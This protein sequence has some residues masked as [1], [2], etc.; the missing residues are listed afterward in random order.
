LEAD[1]VKDIT[2][3]ICIDANGKRFEGP[4]DVPAMPQDYRFVAGQL[5]AVTRVATDHDSAGAIQIAFTAVA[6]I[7]KRLDEAMAHG[8]GFELTQS[9]DSL[10]PGCELELTVRIMKPD[11]A[12]P[13]YPPTGSI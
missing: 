2:D 6:W 4:P 5:S 8:Q 1:P 9:T 12:G 11:P 7:A 13:T 3:P 10:P